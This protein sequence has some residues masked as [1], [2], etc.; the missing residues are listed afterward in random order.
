M[1]SWRCFGL[2]V[3]AAGAAAGRAGVAAGPGALC[4]D[5]TGGVVVGAVTAVRAL[6]GG[7]AGACGAAVA[8]GCS[9]AG[10]LALVDARLKL[11]EPPA[12]ACVASS[13]MAPIRISLRM[14]IPII[15]SAHLT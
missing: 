15:W 4:V 3:S 5:A 12:K 7:K 14:T 9:A 10:W 1:E 2:A 11:R 8:A 13:D 6:A